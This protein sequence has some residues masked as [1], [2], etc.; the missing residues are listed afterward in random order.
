M[1]ITPEMLRKIV[2]EEMNKVNNEAKQLSES[3]QNKYVKLTPD[4]LNTIIK[5]EFESLKNRKSLAEAF[6]YRS[7]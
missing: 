2:I 3:S 1:K 6:G 7:K 5:E 4:Y